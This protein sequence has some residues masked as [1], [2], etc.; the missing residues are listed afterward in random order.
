MRKLFILSLFLVFTLG[1]YGQCNPAPFTESFETGTPTITPCFSPSLC[2][3]R[4]SGSTPSNNTGPTSAYDG[5]YYMYVETSTPNYPNIGPFDMEICVDL[6]GLSNPALIFSYHMYGATIG[7]L[8]VD[9][10]FDGVIWTQMWSLSG[11]LANFGLPQ[12]NIWQQDTID[13]SSYAVFQNITVRFSYTSGMSYTGDC[14]VDLIQFM[15]LGS[16]TLGC[17]DSTACCLFKNMV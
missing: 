8:D 16:P 14:A 10:S 6:T 1:S 2:W 17:M 7:T 15:E 3:T 11:L 12:Y 9:V 4:T 13:L 5:S